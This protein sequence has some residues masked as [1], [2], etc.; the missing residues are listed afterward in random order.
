MIMLPICGLIHTCVSIQPQLV[1][2]FIHDGGVTHEHIQ[3]HSH[4]LEGARVQAN[5]SGQ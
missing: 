4:L 1:N 5:V 3:L 2:L